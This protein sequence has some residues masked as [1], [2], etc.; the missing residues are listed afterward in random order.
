MLIDMTDWIDF[1]DKVV[2]VTGSSRGIGAGMIE[3]FNRHGARCI[4]N[5]VDDPQG[6]NKGD[7]QRVAG[8]LTDALLV[9][10]DVANPAQ[11]AAMMET[12]RRERDGLDVLVN[13]A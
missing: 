10:C 3:A 7:A 1:T 11:V 5:Y 4:V 2:L 6:R 8:N 12:I 9:E 13:N